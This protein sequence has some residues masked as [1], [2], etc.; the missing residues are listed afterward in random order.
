MEKF[1]LQLQ[2]QLLKEEMKTTS[3]GLKHDLGM[4]GLKALLVPVAAKTFTSALHMFSSETS[5]S[6]EE[7]S[8]GFASSIPS[9][10]KGIKYGLDIYDKFSEEY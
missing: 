7:G 10:L 8:N 6:E 5:E 4:L 3:S 2:M 9:I 1:Q